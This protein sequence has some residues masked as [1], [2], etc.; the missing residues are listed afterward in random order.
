MDIIL[1]M[2]S[3]QETDLYGV[4]TSVADSVLFSGSGSADPGFKIRIWNRI[5]VTQKRPD[6]DFKNRIRIRNKWIRIRIQVTQKRPD[7]D[8]T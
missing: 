5:Q 7:P 8:P 2:T 6:P 1:P 4:M 3:K